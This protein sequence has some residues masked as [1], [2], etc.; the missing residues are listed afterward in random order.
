MIDRCLVNVGSFLLHEE[1]LYSQ[2]GGLLWCR[3]KQPQSILIAIENTYRVMK[4]TKN[5]R[6]TSQYTSILF[7]LP[8]VY[9]LQHLSIFVTPCC[10]CTQVYTHTHNSLFLAKERSRSFPPRFWFENLLSVQQRMKKQTKKTVTLQ[11]Q[12][13]LITPLSWDV[14]ARLAH[15]HISSLI[16]SSIHIDYMCSLCWVQ[17]NKCF[18]NVENVL[19]LPHCTIVQALVRWL[20]HCCVQ[21]REDS[22]HSPRQMLLDDART[23]M[24]TTLVIWVSLRLCV[25]YFSQCAGKSVLSSHH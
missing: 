23:G 16:Y 2:H 9:G 8:L 13:Q 7:T 4:W 14:F 21:R 18:A 24:K 17:G 5:N 6:N 25:C 10:T 22:I 11:Q 12:Q 15:L 3:K 1:K 19:V 20:A